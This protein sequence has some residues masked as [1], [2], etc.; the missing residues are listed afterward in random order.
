MTSRKCRRPELHPIKPT[1]LR[2]AR[3]EHPASGCGSAGARYRPACSLADFP[4]SLTQYITI[5]YGAEYPEAHNEPPTATSS[6]W[7][8]RDGCRVVLLPRLR[9]RMDK[10][11]VSRIKEMSFSKLRLFIDLGLC[12]TFSRSLPHRH[13]LRLLDKSEPHSPHSD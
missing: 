8:L 6:L 3:L 12:P 7:L 4:D 11:S 9:T 10:F 1:L 5:Y 13:S 2:C